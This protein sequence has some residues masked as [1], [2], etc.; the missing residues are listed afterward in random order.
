M[1]VAGGGGVQF[2][3]ILAV[4]RLQRRHFAATQ[5]LTGSQRWQ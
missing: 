1:D 3:L 2:V 5:I 4:D